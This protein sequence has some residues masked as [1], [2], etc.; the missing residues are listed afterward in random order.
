MAIFLRFGIFKKIGKVRSSP[1][2]TQGVHE[3]GGRAPCLVGKSCALRTPFSY[4]ILL[5]VGKNSLY[6]LPEV[7]T[8]VPRKYPLFLFG[9]VLLQS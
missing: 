6:N 5:L 9:V 8:T 7:L 2:R 4:M 1:G 3:G